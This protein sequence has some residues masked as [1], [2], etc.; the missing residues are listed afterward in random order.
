MRPSRGLRSHPESSLGLLE[1]VSEKTRLP[2]QD[3]QRVTYL[4]AVRSPDTLMAE[5]D[6]QRRGGGAQLRENVP[7]HTEIP[8][9]GRMA[10]PGRED[11]R[12][13]R[14]QPHLFQCNSVVAIDDRIRADFPD[15][16]VQ[17]VHE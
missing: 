3:S 15:L 9:V 1:E 8:W 10:R 5:T 2:V 7:A 17:V 13:R 12:I 14:K 11:D 4:P 16:L 6:A